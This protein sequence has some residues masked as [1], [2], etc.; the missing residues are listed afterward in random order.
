MFALIGSVDIS[1]ITQHI[2]QKMV[3]LNII[4]AYLITTKLIL[5]YSF[6][7]LSFII[8]VDII[9]ALLVWLLLLSF[10][11]SSSICLTI[12][13]RLLPQLHCKVDMHGITLHV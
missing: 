10:S 1:L 9:V 8:S 3:Y 13:F 7:S 4:M 5:L 2:S 11:L 12:Y 6:D